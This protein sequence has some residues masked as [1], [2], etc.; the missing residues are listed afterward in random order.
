[1]FPP[2]DIVFDP[3]ILTIGTGMVEH[4]NYGVDF[5]KATKKIKEAGQQVMWLKKSMVVVSKSFELTWTGGL[6]HTYNR[7][8]SKYAHYSI[9]CSRISSCVTLHHRLCRRK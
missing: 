5:I 7:D 2:E 1:M 6:V 3:N 4:N 9:P 8:D